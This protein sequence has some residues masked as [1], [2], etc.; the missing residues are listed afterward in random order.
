[1]NWF[2]KTVVNNETD[3]KKTG[4]VAKVLEDYCEHV[5][6]D[7]SLLYGY[8]S[9]N[10][11]FGRESYGMC[12]A[13]WQEA[14][15]QEGE[16]EVVCK[17]CKQRFPRSEVVMWKWYDFYAPQGDEPIPVCHS[18]LGGPAHKARSA[19]DRED[20]EWEFGERTQTK[21][22]IYEDY[23]GYYEDFEDYE[24]ESEKS[25]PEKTEISKD[26]DGYW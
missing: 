11:S 2:T 16:E 18:C 19:R 25:S 14:M 17:D 8:V 6:E 9:E 15:R 23:I 26:D 3:A 13:C 4:I 1:M 22:E 21:T 24:Q 7:H 12:E 10:D 20:Y 5:T